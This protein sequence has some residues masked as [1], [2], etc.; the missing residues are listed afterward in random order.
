MNFLRKNQTLAQHRKVSRAVRRSPLM[1]ISTA[2]KGVAHE[3]ERI[4]CTLPGWFGNRRHRLQ[5]AANA[6]AY[7]TLTAHLGSIMVGFITVRRHFEH[8]FEIHCMAVHAD[9]RRQGFGSALLQSAE[10]MARCEGGKVMQVKTIS[11]SHPSKEYAETRL[12][13]ANAGYIPLEEFPLLW[14]KGNP[15]LQLVKAL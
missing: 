11:P 9:H 14:S 3:C 7:P 2:S 4:L 12:F 1:A 8:S 13:Y 5:F 15:C 6:E 10:A